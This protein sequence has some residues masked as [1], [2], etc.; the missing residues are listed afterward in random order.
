M[1]ASELLTDWPDVIRCMRQCFAQRKTVT[2][3]RKRSIPRAALP[4]WFE[5]TFVFV[6]P[7]LVMVHAHDLSDSVESENEHR[8]G[9]RSRCGPMVKLANGIMTINENRL[10]VS[11]NRAVETMFGYRRGELT[12]RNVS[13]LMTE[14]DRDRNGGCIPAYQIERKSVV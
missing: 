14:H 11:V 3:V 1:T 2:D 9:E 8:A 7:D 6:P 5:T 10:I 13:T 12:D 4:R